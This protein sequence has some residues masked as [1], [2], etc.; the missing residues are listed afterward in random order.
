[1]LYLF[2]G[3][4][5]LLFYVYL[6][7][8][9]FVGVTGKIKYQALVNDGGDM[10]SI[11]V[12]I[13]AHNEEAVIAAKL[14]NH[15][16]FDYPKQSYRLYVVSDGSTDQT[17]TIAQEYVDKY[18]ESVSLKIVDDRKGKTNAI[19]S[20]M[21]GVVEDIVVFSDAN[22]MLA[23]DALKVISSN[24][25][26]TQIGSVAGQLSYINEGVGGVAMGN[27]LYWRY[28]EFIK[29]S[30]SLSGS[31]MGADGSI[32]SIR[33][34][35]FR[36]L[37]IFVSDDFC[38]S[39]GVVC[40]GYRLAFNPLIKAFEKGSEE[41]SEEFAR[42]VRIG[43]RSYNTYRYMKPDFFKNLTLFD[44]W[45]FYSHKVLR[46][47]SG[48]FMIIALVSHL[49][50]MVDQL[51]NYLIS[52]LFMLHI[53]VYVLAALPFMQRSVLEL[54]VLGKLVSICHYFVIAN[55][56]ASVGIVKSLLGSKII[57]WNKAE[58]SR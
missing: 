34:N 21:P 40:Q 46:W 9:I 57:I 8:P 32:F 13:A 29:E 38:T 22:V 7:Y 58:T 2:F 55:F 23:P 41:S 3:S 47:Y 33:R 35:L 45:K 14:E 54:S 48:L 27:G 4:L 19:N 36:T 31:M 28:E 44:K 39:M 26:D 15:L 56:A 42:K 37:P 1:M 52:I 6:L 20:L 24:F 10:H 51:S 12:V 18:P 11:A 17:N 50:L 16:N 49:I 30:E 25:N 43:N 53:G 5:F